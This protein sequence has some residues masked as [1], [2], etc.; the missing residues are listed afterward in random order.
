MR[1]LQTILFAVECDHVNDDAVDV[2]V[3]LAT[4]FGSQV[5]LVHVVEET[6]A[7]LEIYC[8][9]NAEEYLDELS[10]RLATGNVA[11][12]RTVVRSG[13]P[14]HTI[15]NLAQEYDVDL[16]VVGASGRSN[17]DANSTGAIAEAVIAH[18][19]QPV[20]AVR[21]G[22]P[23]T[24]FKRILCPVDQSRT[25]LRGLQQAVQ[26]A[27]AI[28]SEIVILTVVPEVS[29]LTA[30]VA[31]GALAEARAEYA[32][33]WGEEFRRFVEKTD[34]AGVTWQTEVRHGVPHEQICRAAKEHA[35]DLIVMGATGRT[36]LVQVLLGGTTRRI[37]R[38]LPCSLLAVKRDKRLEELLEFDRIAVLQHLKEARSLSDA[39]T[40]LPAITMYRHVLKCD[41]FHAQAIRELILLLEKIGDTDE[42]ARYLRRLSILQS[43]PVA[44]DEDQPGSSS[45]N[46]GVAT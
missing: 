23:R 4:V 34:L 38:Y 43:G 2:V 28:G 6:H 30:V 44:T 21:S 33:E 29:W 40:I 32:A 39:G 45:T 46:A 18:A 13:S 16:I 9:Q 3:R 41:P 10:K 37:I 42:A 8:I 7:A 22:D 31:T 12:A 25:S 20:L 15:I 36:G 11:V 5:S 24:S 35:S 1:T 26:L 19:S 14:A 27:R 17:A